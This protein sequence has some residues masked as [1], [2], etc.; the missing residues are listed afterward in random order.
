M[1]INDVFT[2]IVP[3]ERPPIIFIVA[4]RIKRA[5]A[6]IS[7]ASKGLQKVG[8]KRLD[9]DTQGLGAVELRAL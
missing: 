5:G 1:I 8:F 4:D 9:S 6:V 2:R 3:V 7:I